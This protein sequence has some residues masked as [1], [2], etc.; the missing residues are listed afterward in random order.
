MVL[1]KNGVKPSEKIKIYTLVDNTAGYG[2]QGEWGLSFYIEAQG[3]KILFD[4]GMT[5]LASENARLA[6]IDLSSID[7]L[8]LSHGHNDHTGGLAD[9]LKYTGDVPVISHPDIWTKKYVQ[10][11][12]NSLDYIGIPVCR[13]E[14]ESRGAQFHL[15]TKTFEICQSIITTGEVELNNPYEKIDGDLLV[16]TAGEFYCDPMMDDLSLIIQTDRGLVVITGCAHRG[17]VNTLQ[18]AQKITGD[19]RILFAIGGFHLYQA[20]QERLDWTVQTLLSMGIQKVSPCHCTGFHA[21]AQIYQNMPKQ[22]Q[23]IY[24]GSVI[25]LETGLGNG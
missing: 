4:T 23:P 14:L 24:A 17:I 7:T 18:H 12:Q 25:E 19:Q 22:Y 8:V 5:S 6:K 21:M 10:E 2:F 11:N 1:K 3:H 20:S 13:E 15:T 9:F 16:K